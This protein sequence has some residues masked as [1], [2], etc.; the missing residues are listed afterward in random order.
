M[1]KPLSKDL[2]HHLSLEAQSRGASSLKTAFKYFGLPGMVF[3]GGGLPL[4]DSFPFDSVSVASPAV[5]FAAGVCA[6][7]SGSEED[8][9]NFKI[10]KR[11][12]ENKFK[13]EIPLSRSLQYGYTEGQPELVEFLKEHTA[14]IHHPPYEDW[15]VISTVGN[16]QAWDA[17]LRNFT[18][19]GDSILV[20]EYTFPS[21]LEAS[22]AQGIHNVPM[23]MDDY[24]IV[25][26][27]LEQQLAQ[28]VGAKPKFIYTIP[29]GQNPTGSSLPVDRRKAIYEICCKHDILIIEDEPYY[30][31]Q[32]EEYT[33]DVTKRVAT[34]K[35]RDEF[36]GALVTSF[37]S[38][39]IEGRVLRLD[40]FSKVLAP[41]TRMGWIVAQN[42]FIERFLRIHE[43]TIQCPSG[44]TQSIVSGTLN[45]WGQDGYLDWL[46]ELR[47]DYTSKRDVA[48][49]SVHKYFPKAVISFVPPVAGM[50][51]T[52]DFDASKHPKFATEFGSDPLKVENAIYEAGLKNNCLMIPGSW[53]KVDDNSEPPQPA[54]EVSEAAKN[55]IF[56][57]GTYAAVPMDQLALGLKSFGEA[58]TAEFGL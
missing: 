32:M 51:F 36:V 6:K 42:R 4:S 47:K 41:G 54:Q 45:R 48:I 31:L 16:T 21:A 53:F 1:T 12:E 56:F 22:H 9:I 14:L 15:S 49:D 7:P 8:T 43:V 11:G 29:T 33:Q 26:E 3:L 13:T 44:F 38:L 19:R 50:F 23:K 10:S 17:V 27:A 25:P 39:D 58:A 28:W 30:F 24:G 57:R 34:T 40:S 52:V 35:S 5:P 18:T 55:T 2:S 37:L 46:I 20:E